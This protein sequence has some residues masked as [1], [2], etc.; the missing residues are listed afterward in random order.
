MRD[1]YTV[2][3]VSRSATA[4]EL[5]KAYRTLAKKYHPDMHPGDNSMETKFREISQAYDFLSDA[6][7]RGRYD[8]GEIDASGQEKGFGFGGGRTGAGAGGGFGGF[9]GSARARTGGARGRAGGG[10]GGFSAE[11]IFSDLFGQEDVRGGSA[12][13]K[14]DD[15]HLTVTVDFLDALKGVQREVTLPDGRKLKVSIP[16]GTED[17]KTLRLKGQGQ[18]GL[19]GAPAGDAQC[20][21]RVRPHAHFTRKG[22]DLYLDLPVTLGEAING[23]KVNVPTMDGIVA[24]KVPAGSNTGT[25]LRLK[26]KGV[27]GGGDFR[28]D[29]YV[30]LQVA[31]PET[32]DSELKK[33]LEK[34]EKKH[35]YDPRAKMEI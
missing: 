20:K 33:A 2:L 25:T 30:V 26:G 29:Q 8:R 27:P 10:F 24:L 3:G 28:G 18:A 16:K 35:S 15:F 13:M 21:I 23:G 1:P 34:W 4:D 11:D 32:V 7:R 17:G 19:G 14:G 12:R 9:G 6:T 22:R 5:K 31:L